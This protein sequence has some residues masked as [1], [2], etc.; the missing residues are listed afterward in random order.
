MVQPDDPLRG[1]PMNRDAAAKMSLDKQ[2]SCILLKICW[3]FALRLES[4]EDKIGGRSSTIIAAKK[5][6]H[7]GITCR[8]SSIALRS[9]CRSNS[10]RHGTWGT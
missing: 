6:F 10:L 2:N 3:E 9:L 4:G 1:H 8:A 7:K 5:F